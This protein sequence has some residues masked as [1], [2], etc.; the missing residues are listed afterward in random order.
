MKALVVY[1]NETEFNKNANF[2]KLKFF[3]E[4]LG[5]TVVNAWFSVS[6]CDDEYISNDEIKEY[7]LIIQKGVD[8]GLKCKARIIHVDNGHPK[9]LDSDSTIPG[10]LTHAQHEAITNV[11]RKITLREKFETWRLIIF[12]TLA[13]IAGCIWLATAIVKY[14]YK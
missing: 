14:F 4:S 12:A 7:D 3:L 8:L 13:S 10:E 6:P 5:F 2:S 11:T 1:A 9:A